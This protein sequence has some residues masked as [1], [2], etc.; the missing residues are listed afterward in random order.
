[1]ECN[2]FLLSVGMTR[3]VLAE[4]VE[5]SGA[6][7]P[8]LPPQIP[9]TACHFDWKT[10]RS[11]VWREKSILKRQVHYYHNFRAMKT[12]L[13]YC[14]VDQFFFGLEAQKDKGLR[15]IGGGRA[16]SAAPPPT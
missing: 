3:S 16:K 4:G 2:R 1:L 11:R 12:V 7:R 5:G 6:S 13:S 9:N 10:L 14:Y 8:N 15:G